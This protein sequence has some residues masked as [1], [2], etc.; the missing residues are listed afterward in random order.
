ME[1]EEYIVKVYEDKITWFNKEGQ[2]HRIGGPAVEYSNG[3]K[4]YLQNNKYH[5][6]D[7]PA[8][9]YANGDKVWY[10][11][12]KLHRIDGPA[13]EWASGTKDWYFEGKRYSK[14]EFLKKTSPV[15]EYTVAQICELLDTKSKL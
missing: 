15:K 10:Q 5:R 11:N 9:E 6:L 3:T 8:I 7:G 2:A 1:Y 14:E 4:K 13:A 12:D